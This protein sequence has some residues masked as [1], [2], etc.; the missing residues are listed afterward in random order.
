MLS[1]VGG[2]PVGAVTERPVLSVQRLSV[3]FRLGRPDRRQRP[4]HRQRGAVVGA[5]TDVSFVL[6]PGQL[7]ALVG[8]S[9]CG[10]SVLA[11]AL[12]GLL[13][14]NAEVRGHA[15]LTGSG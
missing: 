8:E 12:L 7:L 13:P 1:G 5:V 4:D 14:A 9:G 2:S 10:K 3:R 15:V 6:R 11:A